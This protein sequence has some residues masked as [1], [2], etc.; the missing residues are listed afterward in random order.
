MTLTCSTFN[1]NTATTDGGGVY[2]SSNTDVV[3]CILWGDT[4]DEIYDP[5]LF[6]DVTYSN[7][8]GGWPGTGNID[9]DPLFADAVNDDFHLTY[10]SPCR[11]AGD[12]SAVTELY[13]FE[14]DPRIAHGNVD[15]GADEFHPHLYL[16]GDTTPTGN[17]EIK[18]IG[19]PGDL[20]NGLLIGVSIFDP[21]LPCDYG[22][23]YMDKPFQIMMGFGSIPAKGIKVFPGTIPGTT[24]AP[25]TV[26]LQA[27]ID[28]WLTNLFTVNIQ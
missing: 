15:M 12:N 1:G 14:G 26:Y 25:L 4:P 6:S 28:F 22:L 21:P 27:A 18:F 9:A 17:V 10:L 2:P 20:I 13:D 19:L 24:P 8:E 5:G 3:N 11:N 23:W 16:T 7:V